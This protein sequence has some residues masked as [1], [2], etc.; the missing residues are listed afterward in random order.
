MNSLPFWE[1]K[2][3]G[4]V[5]HCF[6]SDLASVSYLEVEAGYRCSRHWHVDRLNEFIVISGKI[7]VEQWVTHKGTN[8]NV[9]LLLSSSDT[10][11]I[12]AGA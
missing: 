4:R 2:C 8:K 9:M 1:D 10:C 3:W 5:M 6:S 12:P 7:V 11:S